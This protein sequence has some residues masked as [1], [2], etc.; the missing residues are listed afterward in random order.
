MIFVEKRHARTPIRP[1]IRRRFSGEKVM[2]GCKSGRQ[3]V[4]ELVPSKSLIFPVLLI[5]AFAFVATPRPAAQTFTDLYN[6]CPSFSCAN[7]SQPIAGLVM[8]NAGN[9]LGT[10]THGGSSDY[11]VV[12]KVDSSGTE[13]VLYNFTGLADG[14][15]PV[16][17]LLRDSQGLLLGTAVDGGAFSNGVVF[18]IDNT[19]KESVLHSFKGGTHD[20]CYPYQ[21]LIGD[22]K[23]NIYGTTFACGASNQGVVFK[24]GPKGKVT[25]LHSFQGG[26]NDG[27][28]PFYGGLAMDAAGNLYGLTLKG[29]STNHGA[30]YKL[31]QKG[32]LTVLHSF[33]GGKKD[34]CYPQGIPAMDGAGNLYG[35][36]EACGASDAGIVWKVRPKGAE[37]ILHTFAGGSSDGATPT[38]GVVRDSSGN[39]YG[40][41]VTGG[42]LNS[43]TVYELST[44]GQL[45][46][47]HKFG[48]TE[49]AFP[50]G[51]L[52]RDSKGR[53]YGTALTGGVFYGGT[54]WS[55]K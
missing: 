25:V 54:V 48:V 1:I 7:G 43:G 46:L 16:A 39:L 37:T 10:A 18:R 28:Y 8:D 34:G 42:D 22:R 41:T 20:G 47:L 14:G 33:V 31:T 6:F 53:L 5:I 11:G 3:P 50:Y 12:F 23:G 35:T 26:A 45:T 30:L 29:G 38:C 17:T 52:L 4:E 40:N 44:T 24:L 15:R 19:G 2:L 49:G 36:T 51:G 21:S 9:L 32:V 55:L 27:S 13:S